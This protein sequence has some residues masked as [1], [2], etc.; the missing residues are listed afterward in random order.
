MTENEHNNTV[1]IAN[2]MQLLQQQAQ[3]IEVLEAEC[4]LL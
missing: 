3:K 1:S 2:I 4:Q